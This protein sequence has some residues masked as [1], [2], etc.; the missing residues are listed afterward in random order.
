MRTKAIAICLAAMFLS[1][2]VPSLHRLYDKQTTVSDDGLPGRWVQEDDETT[3]TFEANED[4]YKV[5]VAEKDGKSGRFEAHLVRLGD[6]L[7]MDLYPSTK[8]RPD[9]TDLYALHLVPA[10]TLWRV[11]RQGDT[12]KLHV[13]NPTAV[14]K[15]L[16]AD[17]TLVK[18]E[19]PDDGDGVVLTAGTPELQKFVARCAKTKDGFG[20]PI[21]LNRSASSEPEKDQPAP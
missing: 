18:H 3:W 7:F 1:G 15:M 19:R 9:M 21:V 11:Q 2:C 5:Q 20:E 4:G 17:P 13:M 10:H 8:D 12:L 16:K 14:D 6:L